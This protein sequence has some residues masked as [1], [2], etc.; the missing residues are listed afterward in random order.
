VLD[1]ELDDHGLALAR[2]LGE[3]GGAGVELGILK[4]KKYYYN[5]LIL[6]FYNKL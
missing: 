6:R 3:R 5:Y 1:G 4:I 2:E